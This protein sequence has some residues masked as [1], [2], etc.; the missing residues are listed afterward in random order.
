[1]SIEE[2]KRLLDI[3]IP[4]KLKPPKRRNLPDLAGLTP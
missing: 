3:P 1:M 4:P 2:L